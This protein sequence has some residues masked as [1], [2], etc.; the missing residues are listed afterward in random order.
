M[1]IGYFD[2][3]HFFVGVF[4]VQSIIHVISCYD[5]LCDVTKRQKTN[6]IFESKLHPLWSACAALLLVYGDVCRTKT[7]I[8]H[9]ICQEAL[10]LNSFYFSSCK[11]TTLSDSSLNVWIKS[12]QRV[13]VC[14]WMATVTCSQVC[15]LRGVTHSVRRETR[16]D[17]TERSHEG[18]HVMSKIP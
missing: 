4:V 6:K 14:I 10:R 16:H 12:V 7:A 15:R 2:P 11:V 9:E 3:Q 13:T 18:P 5:T 1:L 17:G 8:C